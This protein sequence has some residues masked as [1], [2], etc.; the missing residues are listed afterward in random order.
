ML[1]TVSN[2]SAVCLSLFLL[3][4]VFGPTNQLIASSAIGLDVAL[5][6]EGDY[7]DEEKYEGNFE[8]MQWKEP[9]QG[10]GEALL[11]NRN[12]SRSLNLLI[13][14]RY[15]PFVRKLFDELETRPGGYFRSPQAVFEFFALGSQK[16]IPIAVSRFDNHMRFFIC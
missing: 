8:V 6:E 4:L 15:Y 2:K 3:S 13:P 11:Q 5:T 10:D 1:A 12:S 9:R 16:L 14:E 7:G